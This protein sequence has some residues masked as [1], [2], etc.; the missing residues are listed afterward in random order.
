LRGVES[1]YVVGVRRMQWKKARL[2]CHSKKGELAWFGN[3]T[4]WER[5]VEELKYVEG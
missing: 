2:W 3:E 1:R 4:E 5:L